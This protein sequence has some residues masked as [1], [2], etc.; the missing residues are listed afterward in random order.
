MPEDTPADTSQDAAMATGTPEDIEEMKA[1]VQEMEAEA[2][3]LREMQAQAQ[4]DGAPTASA[5][6]ADAR[7][8]YIGNVDYS[9]TPEEVQEHF[10]SCGTINRVTIVCDKWSGH[11]KGFAYVEFAEASLVQNALLLNDSVFKGRQ[12]KVTAKRTN[13]PAFQRGR[14]RGRGRG[15]F[16]GRRPRRGRRGYFAPY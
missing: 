14:G 15:G 11:P 5:S 6:D 10:Q 12:L 1:R 7:S 8:I 2:E 4:T 13:I 16:R 3:K 9:S